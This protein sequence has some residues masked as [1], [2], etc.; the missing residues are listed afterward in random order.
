MRRGW[1]D[2]LRRLPGRVRPGVAEAVFALLIMLPILF[3]AP[4]YDNVGSWTVELLVC[5]GAAT[6]GFSPRAGSI[7]TGVALTA[8]VMFPTTEPR[9]SAFATFIPIV[10]AVAHRRLLMASALTAWFVPVYCLI[11]VGRDEITLGGFVDALLPWGFMVGLAWLLGKAIETVGRE[12]DRLREDRV[13]AVQAQRRSIARDLHDTVAYSTTSIILRAEQAKLRGVADPEVLADLDYII[14]AGRSSMRDLR[15]MMETLRRND[16]TPEPAG[17]SPWQISSMEDVIEG[18]LAEL[19]A[20]GFKASCH[21]DADL[22]RLSESVKETLAKVVVEATANMIK[23]GETGLPCSILIEAGGDEIEAVF[24]NTPAT[25]P[26]TALTRGQSNHLG[27][28]GA[29]ERVEALGGECEVTSTA[30]TWVMRA[31]IPLGG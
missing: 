13:A 3:Y 12:Q 4:S 24:I 30:P 2:W 19:G 15:G 11:E 1:A 18:R 21:V 31:R 16:P 17:H 22:S 29:R 9:W 28:V 8:L 20:A 5:V 14:G 23:H 6:V 27:L 7:L 25:R 26:A 10:W